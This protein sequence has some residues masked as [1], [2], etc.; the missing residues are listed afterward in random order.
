MS[1]LFRGAGR[2]QLSCST[3]GS[4]RRQWRHILEAKLTSRSVSSHDHYHGVGARSAS[5]GGVSAIRCRKFAIDFIEAM[6]ETLG[7]EKGIYVGCSMG[8]HLARPALAKPDC[9]AP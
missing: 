8:G 5:P 6:T 2:R 7:I 4:D 3:A 1:R 9:F